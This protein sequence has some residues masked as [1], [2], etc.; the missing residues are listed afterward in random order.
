MACEI[1]RTDNVRVEKGAWKSRCSITPTGLTEE[2]P[3]LPDSRALSLEKT[4]TSPGGRGQHQPARPAP[5]PRDK[6]KSGKHFQGQPSLPTPPFPRSVIPKSSKIPGKTHARFIFLKQYLSLCY[7]DQNLQGTPV[8]IEVSLNPFVWVSRSFSQ[9]QVPSRWAS[10]AL[11][12]RSPHLDS[13]LGTH[14]CASITA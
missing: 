11:L 6:A 10:T 7:S 14:A 12:H 4:R 8:L 9:S 5:C 13:G 1:T 2:I 3:Q